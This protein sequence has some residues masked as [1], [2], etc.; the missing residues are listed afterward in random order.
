[1][2]EKEFSSMVESHISSLNKNALKFTKNLEDANDLVQD[3]LVK[4]IR[5][6]KKYEKGT[7]LTGW[8][9]VIM[10]NTFLNKCK[11]EA[12]KRAL[13]VQDEEISS[14][15]LLYSSDHNKSPGAMIVEDVRKALETIPIVNRV[16]F[17][18]YVEGYKYQEIAEQLNIPLGTV[19]TR[20]H[21]ARLLLKKKLKV[22]AVG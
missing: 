22:Y 16:P 21:E 17:V 13:I 9:F 12:R 19:K 18:R 7:N 4:A 2:L 8:L 14:V 5:F 6:Y 20:I 3:T 10:K 1:M 11:K 15:N